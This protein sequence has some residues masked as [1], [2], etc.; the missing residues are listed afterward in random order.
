[1]AIFKGFGRK[2]RR[3]Y[4]IKLD[5]KGKSARSR[6]FEMFRDNTPSSEIAKIVG[7]KI[8]TVRRYHQQWKKNPNFEQQHAYFKELLKK[9]APDRERTIELCAKAC[10]ITKEQTEIILSQP[11]GLR[12]LMSGMF[13]F[14][15]QADADHKRYVA[16][17]LVFLISDHLIKRGGNFEDVYFAFRRWLRESQES[18][19]EE[20]AEIKEENKDIAFMRRILEASAEN[21][22][23]G[24]VEPDRLSDQ[25]RHAILRGGLASVKRRLEKTYWLRM[26]ELMA[27]GFTLEQAREKVFQDLLKKGDLKGAKMMREYQDVVHPLKSGDQFPPPSPPQ[28]PAIG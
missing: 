4:P 10:G 21:E 3:K 13:Y 23:Q 28:P 22:R 9:T 2:K 14:P 20:D 12:R 24:R 8:E 18:R 15:G 7:V 17:E 11:H 6:C 5:E 25:E 19:E 27:E 1:M 26:V 16:L